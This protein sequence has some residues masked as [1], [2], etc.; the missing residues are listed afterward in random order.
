MKEFN[1]KKNF[2]LRS[3]VFISLQPDG[4][5]SSVFVYLCF[6][7]LFFTLIFHVLFVPPRLRTNPKPL[8]KSVR[9][10][11]LYLELLIY[12]TFVLT[13]FFVLEIKSLLSNV[14]FKFV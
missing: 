13:V 12:I 3:S 1:P 6:L 7:G 4:I 5:S 8:S 9:H 10:Y 2:L 14:I 11:E